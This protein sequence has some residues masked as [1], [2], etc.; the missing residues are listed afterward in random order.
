M[1]ALDS[2]IMVSFS[3]KWTAVPEYKELRPSWGFPAIV[4]HP[5]GHAKTMQYCAG[6]ENNAPA[7]L[8]VH[9]FGAFGEQWRGQVKA[10]TA[11]GYQARCLSLRSVER[12][13]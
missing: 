9:G 11:A 7:L 1:N 12:A 8:L 3:C 13:Q 10:L 6:A 2:H 5:G 4:M